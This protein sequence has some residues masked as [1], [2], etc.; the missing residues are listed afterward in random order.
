MKDTH[1]TVR[2]SQELKEELESIAYDN[3]LTTSE[4]IRFSL[5]TIVEA[6]NNQ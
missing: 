1:L 4:F 3:L 5:Q 2:L 6:V